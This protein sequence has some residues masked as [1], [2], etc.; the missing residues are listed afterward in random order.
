MYMLVCFVSTCRHAKKRP[1]HTL[2]YWRPDNGVLLTKLSCPQRAYHSP[3]HLR[4]LKV[5]AEALR[6]VEQAAAMVQSAGVAGGPETL[7]T[8]L[9]GALARL[10]GGDQDQEVKEAAVRCAYHSQLHTTSA[11]IVYY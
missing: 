6:T 5:A 11:C 2:E 3:S 10:R 7:L 1:Q 4:W 9:G 8:L